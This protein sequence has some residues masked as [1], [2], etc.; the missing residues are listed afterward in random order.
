[1]FINADDMNSLLT[2]AIHSP[3]LM[4][5]VQTVEV[6]DWGT[7]MPQNDHSKWFPM[8]L[9]RMPFFRKLM[10]TGITSIADMS[11]DLHF[12]F[13]ERHTD[14]AWIKEMCA[15]LPPLLNHD[16]PMRMLVESE[17]GALVTRADVL[18]FD[19]VPEC[20]I[21]YYY[22]PPP[23]FCFPNLQHMTLDVD[24][25]VPEMRACAVDIVTGLRPKRSVV[26]PLAL[27]CQK[28]CFS[29]VEAIR[30]MR[31]LARACD[32]I[33]EVRVEFLPTHAP[34]ADFSFELEV[35]EL[36]FPDIKVAE[37]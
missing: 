37:R 29:T 12:D 28:N 10:I 18:M 27:T 36:V 11:L 1:M 21:N 9:G 7:C 30:D 4:H 3:L 35:L 26:K 5:N 24:V 23:S 8:V 33:G 32:V 25:S 15:K 34:L 19:A 16:D 31:A 14:T 20:D 2:L 13:K 22:D 6:F 17:Y